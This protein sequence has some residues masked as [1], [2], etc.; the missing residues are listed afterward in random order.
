MRKS[1]P[2]KASLPLSRLLRSIANANCDDGDERREAGR[3]SGSTNI[4]LSQLRMLV[5]FQLEGLMWGTVGRRL[6]GSQSSLLCVFLL[7]IFPPFLE[8]QGTF[9]SCFHFGE[10]YQTT[11]GGVQISGDSHSYTSHPQNGFHMSSSNTGAAGEAR[12]LVHQAGRH[13]ASETTT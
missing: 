9:Q 2:G 8:Y 10:S 3:V 6:C 7:R 12:S 13:R 11:G 4:A 1:A 5:E